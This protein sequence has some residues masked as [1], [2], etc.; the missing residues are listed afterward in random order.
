MQHQ[1]DQANYIGNE[2]FLNL[3]TMVLQFFDAFKIYHSLMNKK[4]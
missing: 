4:L 3:P 1:L 2:T